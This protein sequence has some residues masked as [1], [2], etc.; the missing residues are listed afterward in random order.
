MG[1][2]AYRDTA[3]NRA[4]MGGPAVKDKLPLTFGLNPLY[5]HGVGSSP[6]LKSDNQN[7]QACRCT[8]L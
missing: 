8:I 5:N 3:E 4:H 2:F 7:T 6:S 1:G